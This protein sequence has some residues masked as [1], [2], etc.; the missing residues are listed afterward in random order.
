M[1]RWITQGV[2]ALAVLGL[3]GAPSAR[4]DY[5]DDD[6]SYEDDYGDY[7]ADR[8]DY[9]DAEIYYENHYGADNAYD[10]Y[11]YRSLSPH[12][13]WIY[14]SG[15]GYVWRPGVV[16]GW[17]PYSLGYWGWAG[18]NWTWISYEPFGYIAYHYGNWSY[19]DNYGW[20]WFPG[21]RWAP[22]HVHWSQYDGY[23]GWSPIPP[24]FHHRSRYHHR[25]RQYVW[26]PN[27]NFL[28]RDVS[29]HVR[30]PGDVW[31]GRRGPQNVPVLTNP[32]RALVERW[33]G[34][35]P[36]QVRLDRVQRRTRRGVLDLY[37][38]DRQTREQ[39]RREG[40]ERVRP[41]VDSSRRSQ[42]PRVERDRSQREE[43]RTSPWRGREDRS[44][45]ERGE[46][47][48]RRDPRADQRERSESR[49]DEDRSSSPWR[50]HRRS[51]GE[52]AESDDRRESRVEVRSNE[53]SDDDDKSERKSDKKSDRSER[54]DEKKAD[55]KSDR[56]S[57]DKGSRPWRSNRD[58][59]NKG[60][61]RRN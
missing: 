4:A 1:N 52:R 16:S 20:C 40:R 57:S 35:T 41:W 31:R 47:G 17:Q 54:K 39:V 43:R 37:V 27:R 22:H 42:Q 15:I 36:E 19:L 6:Y 48:R 14:L 60:R 8:G 34:R 56:K 25:D 45:E 58:G 10:L 59:G 12:G 50:S 49:S 3:L 23:I 11:F 9:D 5:Y 38:P 53:R 33:T 46:R 21:Y 29:R 32:S 18:G 30:S 26:V 51:R 61:S 7:D 2:A 44:Q 28:D 55:S 24:R 13:E